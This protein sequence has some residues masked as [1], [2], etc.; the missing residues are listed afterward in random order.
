MKNKSILV[1]I[2]IF[3]VTSC[4]QPTTSEVE[5]NSSKRASPQTPA[6][7]PAETPSKNTGEVS[8]VRGVT[9][10]CEQYGT[11]FILTEDGKFEFNYSSGSGL[12]SL[13]YSG[14]IEAEL[15]DDDA[16]AC[17][18]RL[19][20]ARTF[21]PNVYPNYPTPVQVDTIN[22][23]PVYRV[24]DCF[25]CIYF[26]ASED[27]VNVLTSAIQL[28]DKTVPYVDT[29]DNFYTLLEGIEINRDFQSV[30]VFTDKIHS[31][32]V[33]ES[34]EGNVTYECAPNTFAKVWVGQELSASTVIKV[35]LNSSVVIKCG[36]KSVTIPAKQL[37]T[38]ET[39]CAGV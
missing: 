36:G 32:Y 30:G 27:Y 6:E 19:T 3:M 21:N 29:L 16:S 28:G 35:G 5:E 1:L 24:E 7:V 9:Y 23:K 34:I 17:F 26:I 20:S 12:A 11:S 33:I 39:L 2:G 25:I 18:V 22:D 38:V 14:V 37:G 4:N 13:S 31:T 8:L 15:S 10:N